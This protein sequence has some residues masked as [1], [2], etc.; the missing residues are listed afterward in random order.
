MKLITDKGL[1]KV[2]KD[3]GLNC[4]NDRFSLILK[5]IGTEAADLK[6]AASY[7][8]NQGISAT[9]TDKYIAIKQSE[10]QAFYPE[11]VEE[12]VWFSQKGTIVTLTKDMD[13]Q[14]LSNCV[15]L[16]DLFLTTNSIS[17]EDAADYIM[18]L[19]DSIVPELAERFKGELLPYKPHFDWEK[20]LV[21]S[22]INLSKTT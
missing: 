9:V 21:E 17:K 8:N 11:F 4:T 12:R 20:K 1:Q 18:H 13:H 10:L 7:L 2:E 5:F 19:N 22:T 3:L 15:G 16:L 6:N 14:R